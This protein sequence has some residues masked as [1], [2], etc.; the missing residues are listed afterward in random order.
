[1]GDKLKAM[2]QGKKG[3]W[4][5]IAA[6]VVAVL[7]FIAMRRGSG[8]GSA[9][10]S[11]YPEY[12]GNTGGGSAE[13]GVSEQ[14]VAD[15]VGGLSRDFG[16]AIK[17]QQDQNAK[18]VNDF[19]SALAS[20]QNAFSQMFSSYGAQQT[21]QYDTFTR[22]VNDS[23]LSSAQEKVS[24]GYQSP[25]VDDTGGS[26][27][28]APVVSGSSSDPN[29]YYQNKL[30]EAQRAGNKGLETWAKAQMSKPPA[31]AP[32]PAPA[33]ASKPAASKPSGGSSDPN[34]YYQNKLDEAK[35][36]GNK[37]LETWAKAQMKKSKAG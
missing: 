7:G 10:L 29:V 22:S 17:Q 30:D 4:F 37:G 23:L 26:S 18:T 8:G 13:G 24:G 6:G 25:I 14:E 28:A 20:T 27:P 35:R 15:L 33:P 12:Q 31:A 21:A 34:T 19:N 32:A 1:M 16:A 2:F 9:Q 5:L 11:E 36:S 3:K